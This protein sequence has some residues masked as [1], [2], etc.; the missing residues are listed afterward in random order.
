MIGGMDIKAIKLMLFVLALSMLMLLGA[1][2]DDSGFGHPPGYAGDGSFG[3]S[4]GDRHGGYN[5][6]GHSGDDNRGDNHWGDFRHNGHDWLGLGEHTYY[7][8]YPAYY[9][10]GWYPYYTYTYYP[11]YYYYTTPV[12]HTTYHYT[13]QADNWFDPWWTANVYGVGSYHTFSSWSWI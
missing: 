12:V 8:S 4:V 1:A 10:Y 13:P 2:Q 6:D 5:G 3:Q 7:R 9:N 11:T